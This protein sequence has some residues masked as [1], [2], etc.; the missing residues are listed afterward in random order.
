MPTVT[1]YGFGVPALYAPLWQSGFGAGTTPYFAYLVVTHIR[2][3]PFPRIAGLSRLRESGWFAEALAAAPLSMV[4]LYH[5]SA[6]K[7]N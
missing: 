5:I 1:A 6:E 3:T 7:S 2:I 4:L